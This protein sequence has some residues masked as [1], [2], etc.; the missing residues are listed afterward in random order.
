MPGSDQGR[1]TYFGELEEALM[2]Q[3]ASL[4][5]TQQAATTSRAHHGDTKRTPLSLSLSL[6]LGLT[7]TK[8][9]HNRFSVWLAKAKN[10]QPCD[11]LLQ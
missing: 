11:A 7:K 1:G 8:K 5:R 9:T 6:S 4:K 3:V 2:H 10:A